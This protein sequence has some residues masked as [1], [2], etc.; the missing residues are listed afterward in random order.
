MTH[1]RSQGTRCRSCGRPIVLLGSPFTSSWR[2][3]EPTPVNGR[4]HIGPDAFPTEGKRTWK[5]RDLI[6]DLMV[7][8]Q[9]SRAEAEDEAYAFPWHVLHRCPNDINTTTS[10]TTTSDEGENA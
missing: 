9:C 6:E 1:R 5:L 3:F 7:R 10:T 8:R 4:T 2:A